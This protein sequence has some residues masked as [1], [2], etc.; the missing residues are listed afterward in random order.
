M[1][2][3]NR[4]PAVDREFIFAEMEALLRLCHESGMNP[5]E[6]FLYLFEFCFTAAGS[7][8]PTVGSL[9]QTMG[10]SM[11][12]SGCIVDEVIGDG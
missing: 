8:V 7:T 10:A 12:Q 3:M 1:G 6:A 2:K 4:K 5:S 11:M 9:L